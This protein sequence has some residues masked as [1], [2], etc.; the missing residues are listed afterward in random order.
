MKQSKTIAVVGIS[1]KIERDSR[2]I[3]LFLRDKGFNVVGVNPN[4]N[5]VE[6]IKVY[7]T[8]K[9]IP[10]EVDIID[11][12][13]RSSAVPDLVKEIL[14]LNFKVF[15]LQLGIRNDEAVKPLITNGIEVIQ[16]KCILIEYLN[17]L[18]NY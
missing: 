7:P 12:F 6:D 13:R 2:K 10:F 16:D 9:D 4:L 11:V 14:I 15:W 5:R 18:K 3:A 8:V 1:D 17:C